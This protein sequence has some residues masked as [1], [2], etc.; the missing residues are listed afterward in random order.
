M[1]YLTLEQQEREIREHIC[2]GSGLWYI[3]CIWLIDAIPLLNREE[4]G[5]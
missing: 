4:F 5:L 2:I 3:P 1:T